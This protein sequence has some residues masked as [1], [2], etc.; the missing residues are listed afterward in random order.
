MFDAPATGGDGVAGALGPIEAEPGIA[1]AELSPR[2]VYTGDYEK[3][4][5][6]TRSTIPISLL[7]RVAKFEKIGSRQAWQAA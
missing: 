1:V 7:V 2:S 6:V 4:R 3:L 5:L